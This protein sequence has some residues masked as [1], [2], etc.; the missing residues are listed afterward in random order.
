MT[1]FDDLF[2]INWDV[3]VILWYASKETIWK[4]APA[5]S[6]WPTPLLLRPYWVVDAALRRLKYRYI[7]HGQYPEMA[8][9]QDDSL[10]DI[11]APLIF[12]WGSILFDTFACG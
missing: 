1:T 12:Q 8:V 5:K 9:Y 6:P 10:H 2:G 4:I 7:K 3:T 11:W